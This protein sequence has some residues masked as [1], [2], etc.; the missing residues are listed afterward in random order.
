MP[1]TFVFSESCSLAEL[2]HF[3]AFYLS[4]RFNFMMPA[5]MT[6]MT[7]SLLVSSTFD[8]SD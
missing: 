7:S 4:E 5:V 8:C 6:E 1:L 2:R 3:L